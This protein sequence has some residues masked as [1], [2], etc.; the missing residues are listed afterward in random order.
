MDTLSEIRVARQQRLDDVQA[1]TGI[2]IS[3]ISRIERGQMPRTHS[4]ALELSRFYGLPLAEFY[5]AVAEG[6]RKG[7]AEG[8]TEQGASADLASNGSS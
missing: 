3:T 1:A 2:P 5:A 7:L 4:R 6:A 8:S